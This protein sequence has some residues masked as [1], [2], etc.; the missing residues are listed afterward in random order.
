MPDQQPFVDTRGLTKIYRTPAGDFPAVKGIDL[1]INRGEFVAVIGKSGSGKS[2]LINLLTGID[3]PTAGEITIGGESVHTFDEEQMAAW[4]GRNLGIVFQ[5]FQLLPTLTLVENVMLPMDINKL[6][7]P[8]ERRERAMHLLELVEMADQARKL[9]AAVSGGQQQRV[10]IARALANDPGLIVADEPTGNLDSR[11]AES[12]FSLFTRLTAEGKTIIMVTHDESQAARTHRAIMIADGEIVNEHISHALAALNYDQL[13]EV[14]RRIE[15]TTIPAGGV[16]V[17]QGEPGEHF[18]ILT[19]GRAEVLVAQP[20]GRDLL[21]DRLQAG[22]YFGEIALVSHGPR[23][24]TVR[25]A[26]DG[27]AE[28]V[29]LDQ[30]AFSRLVEESPALRDELQQIVSLRH[31]QARVQALQEVSREELRVLA[32][33]APTKVFAHGDTIVRQGSLGDTFFFLLE[34]EV[35]VL[36]NRGDREE[37]IDHLG[38]GQYFG[39]LALL[40]NRRRMATVRA[41]GKGVTRVLELDAGAF[42]KLKELSE[43]FAADVEG[44]AAERRARL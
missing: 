20:D 13:A 27:P 35:E 39:E 22:Q 5:F 8:T 9:P 40:G 11:T 2:T 7:A 3:R 14:Q 25:A 16:I 4:R 33:G 31:L 28:V 44:M 10:A 37:V 43:R 41:T 1:Q 21:V 36:V 38:P 12:I 30:E 23:Q 15:P 17:R 42:E 34:G 19:G 24:A 32:A 6:H 26:P 29:A 18:Y